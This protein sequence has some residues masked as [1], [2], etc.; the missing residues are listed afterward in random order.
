MN[1]TLLQSNHKTVMSKVMLNV[2]NSFKF[3]IDY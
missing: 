1:P 2:S 3:H